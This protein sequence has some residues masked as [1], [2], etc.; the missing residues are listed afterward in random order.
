MSCGS[1][2]A[3]AVRVP[4]LSG[5]ICGLALT[6]FILTDVTGQVQETRCVHSVHVEKPKPLVSECRGSTGSVFCDR[7]VE[8]EWLFPQRAD[9]L[10]HCCH[11]R[12]LSRESSTGSVPSAP[13]D[14]Y[15]LWL[16]KHPE[17]K[18]GIKHLISILI[19]FT[20]C[21][22][23]SSNSSAYCKWKLFS[24][25]C[26]RSENV[27]MAAEWSPSFPQQQGQHSF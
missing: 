27:R 22:L 23:A 14:L 15:S 9:S 3:A 18:L 8:F 26:C 24:V 1:G 4:C 20:T 19:T 25:S 21:V 7:A 17:H 16:L 6:L 12:T 11:G 13:P 10:Q 5:V 2:A